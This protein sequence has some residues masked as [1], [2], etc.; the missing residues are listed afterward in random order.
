MGLGDVVE[1]D[2][3][4]TPRVGKDDIIG[5]VGDEMTQLESCGIEQ[6]HDAVNGVEGNDM[7]KEGWRCNQM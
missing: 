7:T 6:P 3:A 5:Y 4:M 2:F 1:T